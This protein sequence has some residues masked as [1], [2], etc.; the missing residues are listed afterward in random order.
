MAGARGGRGQLALSLI[1]ESRRIND[2]SPGGD[3]AAGGARRSAASR[4]RRVALLGAAYRGN[5]EDTRN[6]PTLYFAKVLR[7]HGVTVKIHDPYV[8]ATDANLKH[9]G[10]T[11]VFTRELPE[12]VRN[13]DVI[14]LC[15][16]HRV[17]AED[18]G[19][20]VAM[21]PQAKHVVDACN[22]MR[23]EEVQESGLLVRRHRP[24]Q[25]GC[26]VAAGDPQSSRGFRAVESG[27]ANEVAELV[28]FL[29]ERY[30]P[31]SFNRVKFTEVQRIAATCPTGCAIVD[32]GAAEAPAE[33][34]FRSQ[35]VRRALG[36]V[37]EPV[38]AF[39]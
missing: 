36:A 23:A 6:S 18:W 33:S 35:L 21:A 29:N 5:S 28:R 20:I 16:P 2:E 1:L 24:G 12:A 17:Y 13:A 30:A 10:M 7:A 27:A 22:L 32:E 8:Y 11:D 37:P 9:F 38:T 4:A 34:E 14:V 25:E 26:A 3:A 31:T 15:C 19:S 39:A